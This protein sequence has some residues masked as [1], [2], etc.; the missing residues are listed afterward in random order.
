MSPN[1][2]IKLTQ[3]LAKCLGNSG[4]EILAQIRSGNSTQ[5]DICTNLNISNMTLNR[6]LR[7]LEDHG[8]VVADR[9]ARRRAHCNRRELKLTS[10]EFNTQI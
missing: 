2:T 6:H 1:S 3:V 8:I 5:K 9:K 7:V 10:S 4:I